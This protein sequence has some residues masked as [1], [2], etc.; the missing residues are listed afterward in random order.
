MTECAEYY[1]I[2]RKAINK[3][4]QTDTVRSDRKVQAIFRIVGN[5]YELNKN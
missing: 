5:T 2:T 4:L 3:Y 1:G